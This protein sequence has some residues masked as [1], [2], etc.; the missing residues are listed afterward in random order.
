MSVIQSIFVKLVIISCAEQLV[1][2][3]QSVCPHQL[4]LVI[5]Y[6]EQQLSSCYCKKVNCELWHCISSVSL[7]AIIIMNAEDMREEF[8]MR[9][10]TSTNRLLENYR[11]LVQSSHVANESGGHEELQVETAAANIVSSSHIVCCCDM[12]RFLRAR[13]CQ[14]KFK[15]CACMSYYKICLLLWKSYDRN[16]TT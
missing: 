2:G 1:V 9:V 3:C 10:N 14:T 4:Y 16:E 6:K 13:V 7:I 12:C 8:C 5:S 11:T 15:N